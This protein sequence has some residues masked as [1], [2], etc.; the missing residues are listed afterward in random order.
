M[1]IANERRQKMQCAQERGAGQ[2]ATLAVENNLYPEPVLQEGLGDDSHCLEEIEVVRATTHEDVLPVVNLASD[3]G[4]AEGKRSPSQEWTFLHE[5]D[6]VAPL[7]ETTGG[8]QTGKP[9]SQN[10]YRR[11]RGTVGTRLLAQN[12][13][14]RNSFSRVLNPMR[15]SNTL[16]PDASMRSRMAL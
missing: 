6:P 13:A 12:L 9:A 4:V 3:P 2:D 1:S 16:N 8:G 14:V 5:R 15:L 10:G 7:D 11:S